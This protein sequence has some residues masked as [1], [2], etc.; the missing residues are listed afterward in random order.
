MAKGYIIAELRD[1]ARN[2]EFAD[3]RDKVLDTV[4][5]YGGRFLVRGGHPAVVE[6]GGKADV[7]VILEFDSPE[8]AMEWYNSPAYQAILPSRLRNSTGRLIC[9]AGVPPA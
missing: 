7:A 8:R 6:G 1:I 3:Y 9:A 2:D 4:T 5:A